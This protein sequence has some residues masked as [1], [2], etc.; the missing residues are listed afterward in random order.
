MTHPLQSVIDAHRQAAAECI[1]A[2]EPL[3]FR[4]APSISRLIELDGDIEWPDDIPAFCIWLHR[5]ELTAAIRGV[6]E[7]VVAKI[8][9]ASGVEVDR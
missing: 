4:G 7:K 2:I 6:F 8:E 1:D 9:Q 3:V 5:D